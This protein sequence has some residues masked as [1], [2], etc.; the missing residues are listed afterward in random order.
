VAGKPAE[1][2]LAIWTGLLRDQGAGV[3]IADGPDRVPAAVAGLLDGWQ[4]PRI[5][6]MGTDPALTCLDW[7]AAGLEA[8]TGPAIF[9]DTAAVSKAIAGI[10]E[11][12]AVMLASGPDNPVTLAFVPEAHIVV[13]NRSDLVACYEDAWERLRTGDPHGPPRTVNLIAGPSRTADIGGRPV[14]G[15]HGPRYFAVVAF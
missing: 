15:A 9:G 6:R 11:V 8:E 14:L 2:L 4:L 3:E 7:Q 13:M 10:G 12:G 1:E 5:V